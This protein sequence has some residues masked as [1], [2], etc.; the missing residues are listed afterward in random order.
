MQLLAAVDGDGVSSLAEGLI[1]TIPRIRRGTTA[2]II[3]P[4][5][6]TDW[7]RPLAALRTRGIACVAV[8]FDA[9]A[10]G[11]WARDEQLRAG[12]AA[13]APANDDEEAVARRR[14]RELRHALAEFGVVVHTLVP[15]VPLGDLLGRAQ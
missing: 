5:L 6:S 15:G 2:V 4:S 8:T 11:R 7:V 9:V 10:F 3:T 14:S 1:S 13:E 12:R